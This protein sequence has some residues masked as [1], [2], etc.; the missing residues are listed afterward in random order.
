[1]A[2]AQGCSRGLGPVKTVFNLFSGA[3]RCQDIY[4]YEIHDDKLVTQMSNFIFTAVLMILLG[5]QSLLTSS[6][7]LS[8]AA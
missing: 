6:L 2:P 1:M 3:E 8:A 5:S 7:F 4:I